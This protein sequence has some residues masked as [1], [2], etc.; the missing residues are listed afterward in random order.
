MVCVGVGCRREKEEEEEEEEEEEVLP[1]EVGED[2]AREGKKRP[3]MRSH[4]V[5]HESS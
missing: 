4:V 1:V 2:Q 5:G 3:W